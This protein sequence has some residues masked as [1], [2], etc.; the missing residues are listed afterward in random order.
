VASK[1]ALPDASLAIA[2]SPQYRVSNLFLTWHNS[3][4]KPENIL[5]QLLPGDVAVFKLSD[6]GFTVYDFSMSVPVD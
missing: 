4:I 2:Q 1:S 6:F 5:V 3:D